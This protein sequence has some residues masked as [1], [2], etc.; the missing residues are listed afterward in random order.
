MNIQTRPDPVA[1]ARELGA[2]ID[3]AASEIERT[4][5]IPEPLL[6]HLHDSR[7]FRMLLPRA[8]GGDE[9]DPMVYV[10]ALEEL[11]Q[12][13]GSLAWNTFTSNSSALIAAFLEPA[14]NHAIFG[15]PRGALRE[16]S[17]TNSASIARA[18]PSATPATPAAYRP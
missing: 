14:A 17:A 6:S 7:L 12:H 10:A 2:E 1:R 3:A 16:A 11:A 8:A 9:T 5:R 13:D 18:M 15:D 4:R